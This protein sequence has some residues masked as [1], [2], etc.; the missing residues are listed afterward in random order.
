[1]IASKRIPDGYRE[2]AKNRGTLEEFCYEYGNEKKRA[3]IYLPHAAVTSPDKRFPTV[4]LAHGGGGS[5]DEFFGGP[6]GASPLSPLLDHLIEDGILA[7]VIVV[8]PT[9]YRH[10][11]ENALT[12]AGAAMSLTEEFHRELLEA[13]IPAIDAKY[14]TIPDRDAR[15]FGGFSMGAEA[16]WSTLAYGGR[17]VR[18]YIPMSGDF[19][20]VA[21]KGGEEHPV[22]TCDKLIAGMEAGGMRP[23]DCVVF[24]ATGTHDIAYPAM[25]PMVEELLTR[26]PWFS[27]AENGGNLT[28]CVSDGWHAYDWCWDYL[29]EGLPTFFPGK[30]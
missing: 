26:A 17:A 27:P 4:Y 24:A 10:D 21:Q 12:H 29:A 11:T 9:Y 14:P 5:E 16:T 1:M 30:G 7:P 18:Y 22:E 23:G 6:A 13:L 28:W 3:L 15:A 2:P 8:T 25:R 19:W 20:A